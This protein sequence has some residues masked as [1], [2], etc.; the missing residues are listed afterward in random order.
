LRGWGGCRVQ[1]QAAACCRRCEREQAVARG[2]RRGACA[3]ASRAGALRRQGAGP[4]RAEAPGVDAPQVVPPGG[5]GARDSRRGRHARSDT[6]I[7]TLYTHTTRAKTLTRP[8]ATHTPVR[9]QQTHTLQ[10]SLMRWLLG[11]RGGAQG[12]ARGAA[13]CCAGPHRDVRAHSSA[14]TASP[15]P[16]PLGGAPPPPRP[17]TCPRPAAAAGRGCRQ[18]S[19]TS[20]SSPPAEAASPSGPAPRRPSRRA[21]AAGAAARVGGCRCSPTQGP[22]SCSAACGARRRTALDAARWCCR[23]RR[24]DRGEHGRRSAPPRLQSAQLAFLTNLTAQGTAGEA[25]RAGRLIGWRLRAL[26]ARGCS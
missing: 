19:Q 12:A 3:A 7:H 6:H 4:D 2:G 14:A 15:R 11:G 8:H 16:R 1:G 18:T 21:P 5:L 23:R 9:T 17:P 24:A 10:P 22:A 20:A 13:G 25:A 26:R